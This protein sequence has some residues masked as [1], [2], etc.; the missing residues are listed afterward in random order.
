MFAGCRRLATLFALLCLGGAPAHA[1]VAPLRYFVPGGPFGFGNGDGRSSDAYGN[2]QGSGAG[3]FVGSQRGNFDWSG[4][5]QTGL[6]SNFSA[7]SY[8]SSKFGYATK[9][10]GGLP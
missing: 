8:D 7:L 2:A 6:V 4:L 9:T 1:Q 10:S 5:S 3:F